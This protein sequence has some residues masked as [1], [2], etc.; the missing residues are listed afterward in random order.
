[1]EPTVLLKEELELLQSM[2]K[3]YTNAKNALGDLEL[4]KH[5]ILGDI[6]A[7]RKVSAENEK[8]LISKYGADAIINIQTGEITQ[9]A[10]E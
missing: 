7:I 2:S 3:D 1:M 6:D 5:D 9:K 4:R 10:K 8:K